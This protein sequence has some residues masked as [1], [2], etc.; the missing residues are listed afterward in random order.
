MAGGYQKLHWL[1]LR[2]RKRARRETPPGEGGVEP[3]R[4]LNT[5]PLSLLLLSRA[6]SI[7][8]HS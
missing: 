1:Y 5:L 4:P 6:G 8:K 2:R 7:E 3:P